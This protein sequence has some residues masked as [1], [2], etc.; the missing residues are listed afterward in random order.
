MH[1]SHLRLSISSIIR[2]NCLAFS[3][4]RLID[5]TNDNRASFIVSI[6]YY[7][8]KKKFVFWTLTSIYN[9]LYCQIQNSWFFFCVWLWYFRAKLWLY[10]K[11]DLFIY[12]S[13]FTY[14]K[15]YC[16]SSSAHMIDKPSFLFCN[17]CMKS[18]YKIFFT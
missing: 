3:Y 17:L 12:F 9:W 8:K 14:K 15:R 16:W 10:V 13:Y 1:I 6:S 4:E 7:I 11:Q 18:R 5:C 2:F